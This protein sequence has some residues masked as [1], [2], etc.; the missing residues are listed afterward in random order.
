VLGFYYITV[1]SEM[2]YPVCFRVRQRHSFRCNILDSG[3]R[4]L[5]HSSILFLFQVQ[6]VLGEATKR[7]RTFNDDEIF[8]VIIDI[9]SDAHFSEEKKNCFL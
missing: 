9:E 3:T 4:H 8:E 2:Q 6:D 5:L 1:Y 7:E